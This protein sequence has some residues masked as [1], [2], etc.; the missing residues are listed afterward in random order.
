ML[1]NSIGMMLIG[2]VLTFG[3]VDG[4]S[5]WQG[6]LI[7]LSGIALGRAVGDFLR[8]SV[9]GI[10]AFRISA[11]LFTVFIMSIFGTKFGDTETVSLVISI[12]MVAFALL[13]FFV[14]EAYIREQIERAA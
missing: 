8:V 6:L 11:V 3:G 14:F 12:L 7:L 5:F 1:W 4:V 10:T 13:L 2:V 9:S